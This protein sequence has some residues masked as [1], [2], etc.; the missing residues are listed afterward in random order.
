MINN[1]RE[2]RLFPIDFYLCN[3]CH[4]SLTDFVSELVA[5]NSLF[6]P[7][8]GLGGRVRG[9]GFWVSG[10][11]PMG[12]SGSG[13]QSRLP[14][15]PTSPPPLPPGQ[16]R[17][18]RHGSKAASELGFS[19]STDL[20]GGRVVGGPSQLPVKPLKQMGLKSHTA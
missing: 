20:Q 16:L 18:R 15:V 12:V 13:S 5:G 14:L 17:G 19:D 3:M 10:L 8:S 1:E 7:D 2:N 4:S 9:S 6:F 11:T